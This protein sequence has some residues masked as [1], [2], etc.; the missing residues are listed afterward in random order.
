MSTVNQ[1][2]EVRYPCGCKYMIPSYIEVI[3]RNCPEHWPA[4]KP[5]KIEAIDPDKLE[6]EMNP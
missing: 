4:D 3:P 1:Q 5:I 6:R 2:L